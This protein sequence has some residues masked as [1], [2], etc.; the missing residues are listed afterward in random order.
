MDNQNRELPQNAIIY[1]AKPRSGYFGDY[2]TVQEA[3]DAIPEGNTTPVTIY[4]RPGTYRETVR[5]S[6]GQALY[7]TDRRRGDAG[8]SMHC[9]R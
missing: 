6:G 9:L 2:A 3:I 4:L 5:I 1:V 8:G 7:H